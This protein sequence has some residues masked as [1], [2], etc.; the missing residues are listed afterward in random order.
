MAG[1][2]KRMKNAPK[3]MSDLFGHPSIPAKPRTIHQTWLKDVG[4]DEAP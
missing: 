1:R 4:F 3:K 2:N